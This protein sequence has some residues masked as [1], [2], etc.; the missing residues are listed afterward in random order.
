MAYGDVGGPV[1]EL[2]ITCN[3]YNAITKGDP[4]YQCN[5]WYGV[6]SDRFISSTSNVFGQALADAAE[7][8][9][10]P[11]RV[12]GVCAFRISDVCNADDFRIGRGILGGDIGTIKPDSY[13]AGLGAAGRVLGVRD[14]GIVEVL[15]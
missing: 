6:T 1:T 11:V 15:L 5:R 8:E 14:N 2:V 12:R 10:V 4:V 13:T 7:G 3:A 9:C